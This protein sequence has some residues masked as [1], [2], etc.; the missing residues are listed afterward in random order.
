MELV[1]FKAERRRKKNYSA[2]ELKQNNS[3]QE[4][5]ISIKVANDSETVTVLNNDNHYDTEMLLHQKQHA[6]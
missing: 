5:D 6:F 2:A 1:Q 4:T 3:R